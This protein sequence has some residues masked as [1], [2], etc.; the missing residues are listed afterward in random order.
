VMPVN[1]ITSLDVNSCCILKA[2]PIKQT[3]LEMFETF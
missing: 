3:T 2:I 1:A